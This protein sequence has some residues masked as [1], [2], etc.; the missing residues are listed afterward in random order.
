MTNLPLTGHISES[1]RDAEQEGIVLRE[2]VRIYDLIFWFFR[3]I[4]L[5]EDTLIRT[6]TSSLMNVPLQGYQRRGF[7]GPLVFALSDDLLLRSII[8]TH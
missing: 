7:P 6:R 2:V 1:G 5:S 3:C 4:H 8:E